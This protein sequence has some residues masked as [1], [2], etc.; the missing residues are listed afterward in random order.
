M[1]I[2]RR[3]FDCLLGDFVPGSDWVVRFGIC[4]K[5]GCYGD[6][7]EHA[8]NGLCHGGSL[9]LQRRFLLQ[10]LTFAPGRPCLS[11]RWRKPIRTQYSCVTA[12]PNN[13]GGGNDK[14]LVRARGRYQRNWF[15]PGRTS[16]APKPIKSKAL[17]KAEAQLADMQAANRQAPKWP[18]RHS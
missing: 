4:H 5:N 11:S 17:L 1:P 16:Q 12:F 13:C 9:S 8:F 6:K 10:V 2:K 18:R 3:G 15:G 14:R 7:G